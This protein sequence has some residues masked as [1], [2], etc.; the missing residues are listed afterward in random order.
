ML[1]IMLVSLFAAIA[2]ASVVTLADGV[3]R[4]RN[5]VRLLRG[6]L[7]RIDAV[8]RVTVSY[9]CE[10]ELLPLPPLRSLAISAR[11][12]VVRPARAAALLRAAA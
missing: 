11:R 7:A 8:R 1:A 9:E 10:P 6:D 12:R 3:V 4:G 5:A 2:V